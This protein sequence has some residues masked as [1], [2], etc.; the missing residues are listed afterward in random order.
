MRHRYGDHIG[1]LATISCEPGQA[2]KGAAAA[3]SS[4]AG[5]WL[6]WL[7]PNST[8]I[9]LLWVRGYSCAPENSVIN[10]K[11]EK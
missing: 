8:M 1:S 4:C 2:R 6:V 7:P 9:D 3:V 5:M 10:F 11:Q